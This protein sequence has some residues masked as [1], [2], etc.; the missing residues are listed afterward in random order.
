MRWWAALAVWWAVFPLADARGSELGFGAPLAGCLRDEAS[1]LRPILGLPGNFI[2]GDPLRSG[3]SGAACG[4]GFILAKT[5]DALEWLDSSGR[6]L[7]RWSAPSGPAL[8]GLARDGSRALV[9]FP[10]TSQ[11]FL[12]ADGGLHPLPLDL[13]A[14]P[15]EVLAVALTEAGH[16]AAVVRI[17]D[18][19]WL[20]KAALAD[21]RIIEEHDLAEA[22]APV[23][24]L[25]SGAI[26]WGGG[27]DLTIQASDNT[28]RRIPLPAPPIEF[29]AMAGEWILVKLAGGQGHFALR[30]SDHREELHRLPEAPQ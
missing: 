1:R 30:L 19:L 15:G 22:S 20:W 4:D 21:G 28:L 13:G 9:H 7:R 25:R 10:S 24:P 12:A 3:V 29:E 27:G 2:L 6:L 5:D 17:E 18:R 11:W 14:D 23:L 26:V 16:A 8:F